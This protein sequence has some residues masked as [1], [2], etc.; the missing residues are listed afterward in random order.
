MGSTVHGRGGQSTQARDFSTLAGWL[1]LGLLLF[2]L[3]EVRRS[4][5]AGTGTYSI[6]IVWFPAGLEPGKG[7][8]VLGRAAVL[9]PGR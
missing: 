6:G 8:A 7:M 5:P 3:E 4:W 1:N 9:G 2:A